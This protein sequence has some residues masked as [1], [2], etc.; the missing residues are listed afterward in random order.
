MKWQPL[1][2][3][4]KSGAI[5]VMPTD[6]IYGLVGGAFSQKAVAR[7]YRLRRRPPNK[8]FIVLIS[9]ILDL[10][11][12]GIR[13]SKRQNYFLKKVWP[14]PVSVI[15]SCPSKKF[16][17]LHRGKNSIAFRLPKKKWLRRFLKKTGPVVAPSANIAGLPPAETITEAKKYFGDKVDF[18]LNGGKLANLPSVLVE[19]KR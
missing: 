10:R 16:F 18:Y 14:G 12:F 17:Y 8:P 7:I 6:T 13:L 4:I 15:L 9:S 11:K 3:K 2:Q 5:G 19:I 1:V